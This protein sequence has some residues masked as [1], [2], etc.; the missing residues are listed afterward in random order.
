MR[1]VTNSTDTV[2]NLDRNVVHKFPIQA[3]TKR[4]EAETEAE[5]TLEKAEIDAQ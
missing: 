4:R 3:Q 2:A 5:I 1:Y